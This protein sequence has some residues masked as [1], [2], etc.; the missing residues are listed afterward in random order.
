MIPSSTAKRPKTDSKPLQSA[1]TPRKESENKVKQPVFERKQ[2]NKSQTKTPSKIASKVTASEPEIE[3]R[4]RGRPKSPE[5]K[6]ASPAKKVVKASAAVEQVKKGRG[7][8][9]KSIEPLSEKKR[10]IKAKEKS[11]E[12]KAKADK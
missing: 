2:Q 4:G 11:V 9:S 5:K 6:L 10:E 3:K 8:P 7:R 1:P 12:K